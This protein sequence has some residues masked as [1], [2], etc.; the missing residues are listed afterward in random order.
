MKPRS[1]LGLTLASL[2]ILASIY[3]IWTQGL[4]GESF[5]AI[6]LGLPWTLGLAYIE[7]RNATGAV[8]YAL[9]IAPLV[10]NAFIL[11]KIGALFGKGK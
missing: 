3:L 10:L 4:F 1:T 2:Y 8:L 5:I 11:Y 6:L 7:F 9:L